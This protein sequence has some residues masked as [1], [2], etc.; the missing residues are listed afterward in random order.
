MAISPHL[1]DRLTKGTARARVRVLG[2]D[3]LKNDAEARLLLAVLA[4]YGDDA[5]ALLYVAP[6]R[7]HA[8]RRP[9]DLVLCHPTTGL[10][11]IECKGHRLDEIEG[12]E[13]GF[14]KVRYHN[15]M[16]PTNV[17]RQSEDQ[18]YD[19]QHEIG[20]LLPDRRHQP[21]INAMIAF[22]NITQSAWQERGYHELHPSDVLLFAEQVDDPALLR[23][24]IG[25]LVTQS[26]AVAHKMAP[27]AP[28]HWVAVGK[29]FGNSDVINPVR[30]LRPTIEERQLGVISTI[31]STARVISRMSRKNW[32]N[33]GLMAF[34]A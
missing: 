17:I 5:Q 1:T 23:T 24:H 8:R 33:Y 27:L 13:A 2:L 31:C 12:V 14:L 10:L 19:I 29:V 6:T 30:P 3:L 28:E 11:I 20:A 7:A 22:P 25:A 32:S 16:E 4:A 34:R 18:L 9:P 26:L 15:R 21:L